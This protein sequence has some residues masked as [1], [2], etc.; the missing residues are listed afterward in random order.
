[1]TTRKE[2]L[3]VG[4]SRELATLASRIKA[5]GYDPL[6]VK[7]ANDMKRQLS[8]GLTG[9]VIMD[10]DR[11]E[12]PVSLIRE[13]VFLFRG[14]PVIALTGRTAT[15]EAREVI[16]AGAADLLLLPITEE[17]LNS[18]LSRYLDQ[19]FDPELGKGRRLITGDEGMKRLL[20]QVVRVAKTKATVLIQGESGTGKELI[21]RYLHQ[22]SDRRDG[23]FVAVNC[24]ALPENLLESELF[25]HVKGA[26][27]G[28]STDH[29]GKFQQANRGS[30]LLDEISEMSLSLQAKLLRVL[31]EGEVDPVG[32]RNPV[33]VDVRIVASTNRDLKGW[34]AQGKFREDLYYRLNVFPVRMPALRERPGDALLLAEHF[35]KRFVDELNRNDIRFS[36]DAMTTI[37]GYNWPGNVRELE[38]T[39][40]RALLVAEGREI[41]R[42]DLMIEADIPLPVETSEGALSF[43]VGT[44][45]RE[46]EELLIRRTLDEVSGNRT[47]AAELLGISIRTLRNKLNEYAGRNVE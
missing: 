22:S 14:V 13:M 36:K 17:S 18:I 42:S 19:F 26:F 41:T 8:R 46:M 10:I 27:T 37:L 24:A 47:R 2:I 5:V 30:I 45:V 12:E 3:L 6:L 15:H 16:Q 44:T 11:L 4:E 29:K 7:D 38:N 1:M 9:M 28:A 39:V 33:Q 35:R 43:A 23:P 25:G 20:A 32:G 40:Q 21:A 34:A 31:Q